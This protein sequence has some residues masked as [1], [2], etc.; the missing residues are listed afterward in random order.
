MNSAFFRMLFWAVLLSLVTGRFCGSS[1]CAQDNPFGLPEPTNPQKLGS[2]MLHGGGSGVREYVLQEFLRLAGGSN[3][4][5]VLLPS[6]YVQREPGEKLEAYEE[7]LSGPGGY[8]RW[9]EL[10]RGNHAHFQFLHWDCPEDPDNSRFFSAL[11]QAT[12]IWMPA[13][14]QEWVIRRLAGDP[15]KPTRFQLALRNL[16]A[17]GGTVGASGGG[18][19]SLSETVIAG[20]ADDEKAGWTRA[21]LA[22]GLG[23]FQGTLLDQNF[24]VWSGRV[25]R[26]TDALR[27][28]PQLDRLAR[29]PG[30]QRRTIGIGVD[31][32]TVAIIRGNVVRAIGDHHVHVFV[33]SNGGRTIAWHRLAAGDRPLVLTTGSA[34]EAPLPRRRQP[35]S[36]ETRSA[37]L[38]AR[39]P[40]S[41]TAA[42][43]PPRCMTCFR[44]LP[45][46]CAPR[47]CTV[48][49]PASVITGCRTRN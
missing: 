46:N 49:R 22:F 24:N 34:Q 19:A 42:G 3:A 47:F 12:G 5:V 10:C 35:T 41:C 21:R 43:A 8:G 37:R 13:E 2:V 30:V 18:M 27:N 32:Q 20:N 29:K 44:G 17:R 7:R 38:P 31:R 45:A 15:L 23:L 1:A 11:E 6:D 36:P 25:E 39:E 9:K 33:Q 4:R 28:G 16:L 14:D 40:S 26:L 48:R